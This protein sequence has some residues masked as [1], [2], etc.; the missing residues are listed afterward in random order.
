MSCSIFRKEI[1]GLGPAVM[2][3]VRP[4]FLDSML[5]M[6]PALLDEALLGLAR[7]EDRRL[8]LVYGDCC[9][10]MGELARRPHIR[11][12]RGVNCCDI[13]LGHDAYHRLRREGVFFFLPEWTARWE[14]VFRGELGLK[15]QPLARE[16]MHEMHTRLMYL[17]TGLAEAP[18]RT[19]ADIEAF[20]DMPVEI[21][22]TG[23]ERLKAE[24]AAGLQRAH[25]HV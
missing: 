25:G 6:R 14:Q 9:P 22:P 23:L 5:H 4:V 2:G 24:I 3:G 7:A 11:K 17:D 12:V 8:L 21:R 18:H 10:H 1:A 19:L 16:F 15:D 20:F 13:L